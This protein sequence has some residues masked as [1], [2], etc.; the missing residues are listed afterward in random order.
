MASSDID[1][2]SAAHVDLSHIIV[3]DEVLD[4]VALSTSERNHGT[5]ETLSADWILPKGSKHRLVG[6]EGNL[7]T[8][9]VVFLA[10]REP[11]QRINRGCGGLSHIKTFSTS[12]AEIGSGSKT[13][14]EHI[15][16]I[17]AEPVLHGLVL[18]KHSAS[19][20]VSNDTWADFLEDAIGHG[21]AEETA[22]VHFIDTDLCGNLTESSC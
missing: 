11:L 16:G 9:L 1:K 6:A 7:E 13:Y 15:L 18:G 4:L 21:V 5:A 14:W 20:C 8:T 17:E 22:D 2:G 3:V 12:Y 19:G 10:T